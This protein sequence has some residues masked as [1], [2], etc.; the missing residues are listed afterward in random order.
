VDGCSWRCLSPFPRWLY[1]TGKT[2]AGGIDNVSD[3]DIKG[4]MGDIRADLV[5]GPGKGF[6]R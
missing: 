6:T 2:D 5:L 1:Q 3:L 4:F